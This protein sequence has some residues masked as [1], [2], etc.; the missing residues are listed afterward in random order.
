MLGC[1]TIEIMIDRLGLPGS[2]RSWLRRQNLTSPTIDKQNHGKK[3]EWEMLE[4]LF[5]QLVLVGYSEFN[6]PSSQ[7]AADDAKR[8]MRDFM[9]M[10]LYGQVEP[11]Y[12]RK[13]LEI[14]R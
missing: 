6:T 14:L 13:C 3:P 8:H 12:T 5:Y 9:P 7:K 4:R 2:F 1:W 11:E 10:P